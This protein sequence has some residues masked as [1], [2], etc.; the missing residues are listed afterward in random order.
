MSAMWDDA[1]TMSRLLCIAMVC[2]GLQLAGCRKSAD[3]LEG[4]PLSQVLLR[5][6]PQVGQTLEYRA[7]MNLDKKLF[8]NG[9]WLSEGNERGQMN[10]SMTALER[11]ADG[12]R[13]KLDG[14]WGRSNVAKETD[15]VM[16]D[17]LDAARS[18]EPIISDRYVSDK[19]GTHNLCFPDE[20]V[21][22]GD[23][24]SGSVV[25]TFGDL[26][27]VEAPTLA[28]N[29]R[30]VK[31]V[32]NDKGR[33]C[34]I[35]CRPDS[36]QVEVPLQIGQLGLKCDATGTVTTVREDR[37]AQGKINVGDVLV[38]V[39]G[40]K[41]A[42]TK[43]WHV[44]YERFIEMPD[45]VGSPVVLTV[46]RGDQ[47][48]DVEVTKTFATL[49]TMEVTLSK[50]VRQVIFDVDRGIIVSDEAS[51]QYSVMYR[52]VDEYPFVDEYM[53]AGTFE[54]SAGTK[55]GPRVYHNQYK[56]TLVH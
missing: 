9:R 13:M 43:D 40:H 25:F 4:E 44:L 18:L 39:N 38:A 32:K 41:A 27:T 5:F 55:V 53:G 7:S 46:K 15:D 17:K 30:L 31:A 14:A 34:L 16:R 21:S 2:S 3:V 50:A 33:F 54:H 45:N 22:P 8:E 20:P 23:E 10:I 36:N 48:Q 37:D 1:R 35:E 28:M 47:E 49:G 19:A 51:P 26:A 12:F 11:T 24:W 52:F 56:M 42:T 29:Y 6:S